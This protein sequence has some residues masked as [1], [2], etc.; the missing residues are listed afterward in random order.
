MDSGRLLRL[1]PSVFDNVNTDLILAAKFLRVDESDLGRYAFDGVIEGF[2]ERAA[3]HP[4]LLAGENFGCGSSREQAPKALIRAG[5]RMILAQ[6]YGYIFFRNAINLGLLVLRYS[7][8]ERAAALET[9]G[10]VVVKNGGATL[11]GPGGHELAL[12]PL[13]PPVT[14][15]LAAGGLMAALKAGL[16]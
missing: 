4:V 7:D 3:T 13:G 10:E 1:P 12:A 5:V 15:I 6:S 14:T 16:L 8:R 2:A 11:V 9:G